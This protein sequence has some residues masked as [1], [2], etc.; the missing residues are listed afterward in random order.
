MTG[1]LFAGLIFC[2]LSIVVGGDAQSLDTTETPVWTL[3]FIKVGSE[4]YGQT[5]G[6][7]DEQWVRLRE[8]A[9]RQ[10]VVVSY[11]RISDAGLVT[12]DHQ[13]GDQTSIV[14]LTEY[15]N[16]TAFLERKK[17]FAS[18]REHLS[19][20]TPGGL[21]LERGRN[22]YKITDGHVFLDVP[23]EGDPQFKVLAKQ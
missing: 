1:R 19:L 18:I 2:C 5:L 17:T 22:P 7:L 9:K 21:K 20:N 3:E 15:K 16:M 23:A 13:P 4:Q 6:D 10:G 12:P 14:L 11:H 8:E